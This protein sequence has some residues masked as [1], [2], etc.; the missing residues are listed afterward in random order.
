[1]EGAVIWRAWPTVLAV[2]FVLGAALSLTGCTRRYKLTP[3]GLSYLERRAREQGRDDQVFVLPH[4]RILAL[5]QLDV[6][7]A[8]E[9][10][11]TVKVDVEHRLKRV[12]LKR[13]KMG[14]IVAKGDLNGVPVLWVSFAQDCNEQA[15]AFGFVRT[16]RE[17]YELAVVPLR[18]GYKPAVMYRRTE[19]KRNR[20]KK[21]KVKALGEAN[22]VYA[23][24]RKRGALTVRLD[25]KRQTRERETSEREVLECR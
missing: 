15:C 14:Q 22:K 6:E 12:L 7:K 16:E 4:N 5:Y 17:L 10:G 11:K 25:F 13:K 1:M 20:M 8:Y 23:V 18:E 2:M 24:K 3:D 19:V 21:H 9:A